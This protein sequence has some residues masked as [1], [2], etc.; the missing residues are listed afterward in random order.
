MKADELEVE[1][2]VGKDQV[3]F[4]IDKVKFVSEDSM[5]TPRQILTDFAKEDPEQTTLVL[6][7][8]SERTKLVNLD[9]PIEVKNGTHF[10]VLH[11][12]PTPVS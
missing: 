10:T 6:V 7:H 2:G 8:G 11:N 1:R 9:D 5:L 4:F 3:V 12:G